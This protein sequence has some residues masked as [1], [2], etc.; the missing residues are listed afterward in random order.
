[1]GTRYRRT[2]SNSLNAPEGPLTEYLDPFE[3][4]LTEEGYPRPSSR[5]H[6]CLVADF[7]AWLKVKGI[8]LEEVTHESAQRYLRYRALHKSSFRGN[9]YALR[10]FVQLLQTNGVVA[11]EAPVAQ[12]PV[13]TWLSECCSYLHQERGFATKTI[14]GL[15]V[16]M[17][18]F[19]KRQ[20]GDK[21]VRLSGLGAQQVISFMQHEAGRSRSASRVQAIAKAL[22]TLLQYARYRG[23]IKLDLTAAVPRVASWSMATVPKAIS[24]DDAR[25]ALASC[26][27][28]RAIGRRD[29]AILLLLARLGVRAREVAT[30]AL[31]DIDWA[32]GT[33]TIHGK[34]RKDSPLPLLAPVGAAIAA[35]ITMARPQSQSRRV[36]LSE[37]SPIHGCSGPA[38]GWAVNRALRRAGV[39]SARRGAHQF[40][41]AL[42]TQLLRKG[43]SLAEISQVL[44]H[45]NP[46]T[47][48]IYA[49][50]DLKSLR[51]LAPPWPRTQP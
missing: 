46:D 50:V 1:M 17:R 29:Y 11:K 35:Y 20:F 2:R 8:K 12:T 3:R 49:K 30:L 22:R 6:L 26:D 36:F 15:E 47:T 37:R 32:S 33:L 44:R 39:T 18:L 4:L 23:F 34:S 16:Y 43:S 41:H 25:R 7:S 28:R 21:A 14:N 48:R 45:R 10:R 24:P 42:A 13:E 5:K 31:D 38:V 40:R 27:R 19:L 51:V 9:A